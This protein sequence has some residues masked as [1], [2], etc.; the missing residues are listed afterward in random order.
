MEALD[1]LRTS[2]RVS[3]SAALGPLTTY[4]FGGL[5]RYIVT[6]DGIDDLQD[7]W[8]IASEHQIPV[9][10][11][12]DF[13]Q[14]YKRVEEIGLGG[15]LMVGKPNQP[16]LDIPVGY[17]RVGVIVAG[18]LNPIAAAEEVNITTTSHALHDLVD[19]S[20]L[21]DMGPELGA[22]E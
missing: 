2:G 16:L 22:L 14:V 1:R 13:Q 11:L 12:A 5:A 4:K 7:A 10:A 15:V 6:V 21:Q 18:G 19:F 9:V 3:E 20:F 8:H 17:G